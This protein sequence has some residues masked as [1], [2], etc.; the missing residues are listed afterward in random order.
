MSTT[1]DAPK[2]MTN[3]D[4]G[5]HLLTVRGFQYIFGAQGD[6]YALLL[7]A[8]SEDPAT[9]GALVRDRG[10]LYKSEAGAWVTGHHAL[11]RIV[12]D[13]PRLSLRHEG[14]ESAQQHMFQDIWDNPK[15][16][17]V[18]P[19]DTAFLNLTRADYQRVG[20]LFAPVLRSRARHR[21]VVESIAERVVSG[22]TGDFDLMTDFARPVAVAVVA[23]LLD[24][25][26]AARHRFAETV[27]A[28]GVALDAGLCPPTYQMTRTLLAA[29]AET[30]ELLD[31]PKLFGD[32][33]PAADPEDVL[34]AAMLLT[35]VGVEVT[36]NLT[37]N[38]VAA[39]QAHPD[40]WQG[41]CADIGLAGGAVAESLRFDPP[42]QLENRIATA[43]I[44][45]AGHQIPA[46]AQLVVAVG[47]ANRDPAVFPDP[48]RFDITRESD[49]DQLALS[50]GFYGEFVAPLA[51]LSAE[52]ALR[53]L[54]SRFPA[55][56]QR[57]A[58]LRRMRSPV[59]R[60]VLRFPVANG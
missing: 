5:R 14:D 6:P 2:T 57:E 42:I 60:G 17:H 38:A 21:E 48:D 11:A 27:A 12:L 3:S 23:E 34:V 36:A 22:L 54:V 59:V 9:L 18:V 25:P 56:R 7:R 31:T 33:R 49:A 29:V 40:Q 10:A 16:C 43:D 37:C 53:A 30:R 55:L 39:L 47:A 35:V 41:L 24:L 58:V 1:A 45:L 4:L 44:E 50:G 51:R 15:I 26:P 19:L 20:D 32:L 28:S 46:D 52:V 13:D 8:G